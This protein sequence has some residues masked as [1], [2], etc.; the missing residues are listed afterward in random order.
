MH[1]AIRADDAHRT[2]LHP[3]TVAAPLDDPVAPVETAEH[4]CLGAWEGMDFGIVSLHVI[5][6]PGRRLGAGHQGATGQDDF[7]DEGILHAHGPGLANSSLETEN[8][9]V[10]PLRAGKN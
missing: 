4:A 3:S 6:L 1:P 8:L 9:Q 10:E 2:D 5:T 7:K